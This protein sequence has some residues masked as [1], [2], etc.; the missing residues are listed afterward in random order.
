[1]IRICIYEE[2][3][4]SRGERKSKENHKA[5]GLSNGKDGSP[6]EVNEERE[7]V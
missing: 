6:R 2:G 3:R 7:E 5:S 4:A 1:V